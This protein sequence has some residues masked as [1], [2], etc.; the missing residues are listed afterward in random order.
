MPFAPELLNQPEALDAAITALLLSSP[1]LGKIVVD[2][3][4]DQDAKDEI[5]PPAAPNLLEI[6]KQF[7]S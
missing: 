3:D 6:M 7:A 4:V 1:W 5:T 2:G